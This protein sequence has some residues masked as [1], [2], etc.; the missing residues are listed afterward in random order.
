MTLTDGVDR[1]ES[2]SCGFKSHRPRLLFSQARISQPTDDP[3]VEHCDTGLGHEVKRRVLCGAFWFYFLTFLQ[4]T[5]SWGDLSLT[6][7][8]IFPFK[9]APAPTKR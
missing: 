8:L 7:V 6:S 1:L 5:A 3:S 2:V 9:V 4:F